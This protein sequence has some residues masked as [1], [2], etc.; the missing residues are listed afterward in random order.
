[1]QWRLDEQDSVAYVEFANL[2]VL[3]KYTLETLTGDSTMGQ[4]IRLL[5]KWCFLLFQQPE[6]TLLPGIHHRD[7]IHSCGRAIPKGMISHARPWIST[8]ELEA[9]A[10]KLIAG[11]GRTLKTWDFP[12]DCYRI[13]PQGF[14]KVRPR[15]APARI[16]IECHRPR[17]LL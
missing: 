6:Q 1:M 13:S 8:H 2:F 5:K 12:L 11:G 3:R 16:Y 15:S 17:R 9:F 4:L 10:S 14:R 7:G